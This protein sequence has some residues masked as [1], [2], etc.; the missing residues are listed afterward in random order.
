M[1]VAKRTH[2]YRGYTIHPTSSAQAKGP[3]YVQ[4]HHS[5]TGLPW[6]EEQCPQF[7]TLGSV[8]NWIDR[9]VEAA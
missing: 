4:T 7:Y 9:Q 3:W 8:K 5:P 2:T 1:M 6:V